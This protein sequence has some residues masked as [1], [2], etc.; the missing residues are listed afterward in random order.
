MQKHTNGI[1]K[2]FNLWVYRLCNMAAK[3]TFTV[4]SSQ[5]NLQ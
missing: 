5:F 3:L 4:E 1:P 2:K